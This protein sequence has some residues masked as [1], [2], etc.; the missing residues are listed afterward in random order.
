MNHKLFFA[1]SIQ[2]FITVLLILVTLVIVNNN[3][4]D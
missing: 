2:L 4:N 3:D 1:K